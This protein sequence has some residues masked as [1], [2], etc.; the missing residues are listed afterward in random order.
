MWPN[1][2]ITQQNNFAGESTEIER[3]LLFIGNGDKNTGELLAVNAQ[4]DLNNLFGE[5][6]SAFKSHLTAAQLNAGQ[7]FYAHAYTLA[8]GEDWADA[9]RSA[10][11]VS[12]FEGVVLC[13]DVSEPA[14]IEKA[15]ALRQ[16]LLG[17]L[18][19]FSWFLLSVRG[20]TQ[21]NENAVP[22]IAGE[23]WADYVEELALLQDG[24]A[25]PCVQLVPRLYGADAGAL[26]GRLCSTTVTIADSPARVKTGSVVGL[27]EKPADKD[28]VLLDLATLRTLEENRFSVPMWYADFDGVYWTDGRTLDAEGGDFQSIQALRVADKVARRVQKKA[29][30]R[31]GD[32]SL[33]SSPGSMAENTQ[34][35]MQT[36]REMALSVQIGGATFPGECLTPQDGDVVIQWETKKKVSIYL[37]VR[38]TD[39][40]LGISITVALDNTLA[41]GDK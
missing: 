7:N 21:P 12:S 34:F 41:G 27:G 31:I 19:R 37:V 32:R 9:V 25:A 40:P 38:T 13:V 16:E 30:A 29:I 3:H 1:V 18:G 20:I 4:T 15:A 17:K 36:M 14:E 8:D 33:N 26:A 2:T 5:E 10:Q 23:S 6:E 39:C 28:G 11:T 24:I 22:A 35:F